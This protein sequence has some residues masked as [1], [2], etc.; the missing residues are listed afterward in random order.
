MICVG[1]GSGGDGDPHFSWKRVHSTNMYV[2][3][4]EAL[5]NVCLGAAS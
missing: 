4:K 1:F 2:R 5:L 3:G